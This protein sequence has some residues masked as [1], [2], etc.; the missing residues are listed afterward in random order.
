ML[1]AM[2]T[3]CQELVDDGWLDASGPAPGHV[4]GMDVGLHH[5]QP[6]RAGRHALAVGLMGASLTTAQSSGQ[7]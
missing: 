7:M 5:L 1:Q 6:I 3:L 2:N 4:G